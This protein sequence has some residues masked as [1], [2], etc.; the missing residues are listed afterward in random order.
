MDDEAEQAVREGAGD[1]RQRHAGPL[2]ERGAGCGW[3]KD[4]RGGERSDTLEGLPGMREQVQGQSD[5]LRIG[6]I[7]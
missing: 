7:P 4:G 3:W 6:G 2:A 1:I 5:F